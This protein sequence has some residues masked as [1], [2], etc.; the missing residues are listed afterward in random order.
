MISLVNAVLLLL[1]RAALM[2]HCSPICCCCVKVLE[3]RTQGLTKR[4]A[5]FHLLTNSTQIHIS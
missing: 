1:E 5:V 3:L 4:V 2:L